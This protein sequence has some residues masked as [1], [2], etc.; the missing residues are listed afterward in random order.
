MHKVLVTTEHKGQ[1]TASVYNL[2]TYLFLNIRKQT[3]REHII[4]TTAYEHHN[5]HKCIV[6]L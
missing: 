5:N 6:A 3:S 4:V 1:L 2:R